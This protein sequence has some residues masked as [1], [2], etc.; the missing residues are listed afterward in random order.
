MF[1]KHLR[2]ISII[3]ITVALRIIK[4]RTVAAIR[5]AILIP[6]HSVRMLVPEHLAK[7]PAENRALVLRQQHQLCPE[8]RKEFQG[9]VLLKTEGAGTATLKLIPKALAKTVIILTMLD[10]TLLSLL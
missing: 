10:L 9:R 8:P 4:A 3:R 2:I 5:T 6:I 7:V 1:S